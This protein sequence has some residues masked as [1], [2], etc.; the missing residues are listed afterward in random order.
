MRMSSDSGI[1]TPSAFAGL[2]I[3]DELDLGRLLHRQVGGPVSLC[4]DSGG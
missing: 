4:V 1:S 2:E 3:K